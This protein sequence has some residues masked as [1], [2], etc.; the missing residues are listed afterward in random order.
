MI[1]ELFLDGASKIN[2]FIVKC[3]RFALRLVNS[4]GLCCSIFVIC[5][6][7]RDVLA[8]VFVA[9]LMFFDIFENSGF[10][11]KIEIDKCI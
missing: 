10:A 5:N 7:L 6:S 8:R 4:I 1:H 2:Y 9:Q 11:S 3:I